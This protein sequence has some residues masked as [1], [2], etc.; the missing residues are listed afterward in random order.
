MV[1]EYRKLKRFDFLKL[2][3][4]VF[5]CKIAWC[6]T[7]WTDPASLK[8]QILLLNLITQNYNYLIFVF[9]VLQTFFSYR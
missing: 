9:Q 1:I 8:F 2:V 3:I 4:N 5:C 6:N 7:A